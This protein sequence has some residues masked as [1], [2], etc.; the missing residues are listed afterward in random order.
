MNAAAR[1][2][3]CDRVDARDTFGNLPGKRNHAM[4][5]TM[6]TLDGL[7]ATQ[8]KRRRVSDLHLALVVEGEVVKE[9]AQ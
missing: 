8:E 2:R 9:H 7:P 4:T 3:K 1:K 6:D 5:E